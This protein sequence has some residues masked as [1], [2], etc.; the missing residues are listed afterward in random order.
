MR[1]ITLLWNWWLERNRVR[2]GE[3]RRNTA[4]IAVSVA[5]QSDEFLLIGQ[6]GAAHAPQAR[7]FWSRPPQDTYKINTDGAF[8]AATGEGG[9][10][11]VIRNNEG[12]VI[13][14]GA[15]RCSFLL[16][17]LHA[18][19]LA[20]LMGVKEAGDLG[21]AKVQVETDSQLLKL[22]LETNTFSL[23]AVGGLVLEIKNLMALMLIDGDDDGSL[24]IDEAEVAVFFS[25]K[26]VRTKETLKLPLPLF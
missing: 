22:A 26:D 6:K 13:R 20:C 3:V 4:S 16:D 25:S 15:G 24:F 8:S 14:A 18:E 23:A 17:A 5:K 12:H 9:W 21:M 2:E 1:I 7:H 19:V 10:G 11:F